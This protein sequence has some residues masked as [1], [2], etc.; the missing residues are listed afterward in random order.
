MPEQR[1]EDKG[2]G[3]GG[4]GGGTKALADKADKQ[5]ARE[6]ELKAQLDRKKQQAAES[7]QP[8]RGTED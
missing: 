6:R 8:T 3:G 2:G 7:E 4:G 1:Y 5:T